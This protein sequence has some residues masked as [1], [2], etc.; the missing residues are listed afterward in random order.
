MTTQG[1]IETII[2]AIDA[3]AGQDRVLVGIAGAPGSGKSTLASDL[4]ARLGDTAAVLPMDG[5]HL[6][7]ATLDGMGL[8]HRKG[9]PQTFDGRG[10]V[11]LVQAL[12][13]HETVRYPIF[14]RSQDRT[15]PDGGEIHA[16]I[17]TVLIEGNY[18][19][20]RSRP[21]ADLQDLFDLT[22]FLDIPRETL[23]GRL[24][25]RWLDHG[26]EPA[27][28]LARAEGND[29]KNADLVCSGSVRADI[30]LRGGP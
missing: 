21:W 3:R 5:F 26:L 9:A 6:D 10:F 27:A 12:R 16:G 30:T 25:S 24:V 23:Q 4:A 17:R 11:H 29:M 18:L 8:L 2:E 19:L 22:V 15:V 13:N 7:N 28:A 20:L 14:D 1:S